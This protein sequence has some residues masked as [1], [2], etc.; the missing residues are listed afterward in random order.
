MLVFIYDILSN[1]INI[2]CVKFKKCFINLTFITNAIHISV[3][4]NKFKVFM[5]QKIKLNIA[6]YMIFEYYFRNI[7]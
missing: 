6:F 1:K 4:L 2:V 7:F 5:M 3:K